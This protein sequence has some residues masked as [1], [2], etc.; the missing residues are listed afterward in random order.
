MTADTAA[1]PV[2]HIGVVQASLDGK[3]A[4]GNPVNSEPELS[5][6]QIASDIVERIGGGDRQAE[7]TL[8]A[9]YRPRLLH[10]LA[11]MTSD[12][13]LA[14]DVANEALLTVISQLREEPIDSP[15]RLGGYL[16]GVA[17]NVMR[18]QQRKFN[19]ESGT[20]PATLDL[21]A[22]PIPNQTEL[23]EQ[24]D[25]SRTVRRVLD[26]VSNERYREILMRYY[27]H[28]EGKDEICD[29]MGLSRRDFTQV[30]SR[31]RKSFRNA[32]RAN[33]E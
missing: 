28:Q 3:K 15:S 13:S 33:D 29:A 9:R 27:L 1:G 17:K 23:L 30:I 11:R 10:V 24:M 7:A 22:A 12:F 18:S 14:E 2:R 19:K 16:Y 32:V 8:V 25:V 21:F 20:E 26:E 31:A 4:L 6:G 5:E